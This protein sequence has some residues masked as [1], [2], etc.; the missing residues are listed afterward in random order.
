M[1]AR[2]VG[3]HG[4]GVKCVTC[5]TFEYLRGGWKMGSV[6]RSKIHFSTNLHLKTL[7]KYFYHVNTPI[8]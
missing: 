7:N 3:G 5:L 1:S 2:S 4:D 8:F 6:F